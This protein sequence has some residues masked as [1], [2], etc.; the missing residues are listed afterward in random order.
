MNIIDAKIINTDNELGVE[1]YTD[2]L[3]SI[4][5]KDIHYPL[6]AKPY[7]EITIGISYNRLRLKNYYERETGYFKIRMNQ[8]LNE[9]TIIETDKGSLFAIK[10]EHERKETKKLVAE[11]LIATDSYQE[12]IN[13][14]IM[15]NNMK[16]GDVIRDFQQTVKFLIKLQE[17]KPQEILNAKM[18]KEEPQPSCFAQ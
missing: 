5:F 14:L 17:I 18:E 16:N 4:E 1:L 3:T 15:T 11:W 13:D 8:K 7:Y 6:E 12:H 10:S 2:E 9:L